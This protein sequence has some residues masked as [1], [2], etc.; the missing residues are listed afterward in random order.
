MSHNGTHQ[1]IDDFK[2][3]FNVLSCVTQRITDVI[4]VVTQRVTTVIRCVTQRITYVLSVVT[5]RNTVVDIGGI[6]LFAPV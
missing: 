6:R 2:V 4:S 1:K 3:F 5:Q